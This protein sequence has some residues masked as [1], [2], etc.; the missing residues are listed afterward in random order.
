MKN[1]LYIFA[2]LTTTMSFAQQLPETII[3]LEEKLGTDNNSGIY[4]FKDV[5]HVLDKFMGTWKYETATESLE[6]TFY[7]V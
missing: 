4:Y 1:I 6:I 7:K 3:P 2:L 5:N